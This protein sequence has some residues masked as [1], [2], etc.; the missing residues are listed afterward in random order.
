MLGGM[1]PLKWL[2]AKFSTR[3]EE[4]NCMLVGIFPVNKLWLRSNTCI[5]G[6]QIGG[7][8]V[9]NYQ[10]QINPKPKLQFHNLK[11]L[12]GNNYY[13]VTVLLG[14]Q[15]NQIDSVTKGTKLAR[16]PKEP[17]G[18]RVYRVISVNEE[19][20]L[21]NQRIPSEL[22]NHCKVELGRGRHRLNSVEEGTEWTQ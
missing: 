15:R 5:W 6:G 3:N 22:G 8:F 19:K 18:R 1:I 7:M 14:N 12:L 9:K 2:L 16:W 20:Q 4:L 13:R 21:G 11:N 17:R 10:S